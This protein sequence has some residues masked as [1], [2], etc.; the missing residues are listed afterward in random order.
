MHRKLMKHQEWAAEQLESKPGLFLPCGAGKTLVAIRY[1][2]RHHLFPALIVCRKDDVLTWTTELKEEGHYEGSQVG[3]VNKE[4]PPGY[5][6]WTIVTYD[7]LKNM[8]LSSFRVAVADESWMVKRW[9]AKRTKVL[10]KRT[11][12]IP[13]RIAMSATP[14]TQD[15]G[16]VFTQSLFMDGGKT[17]GA[18]YWAFLNKY[19]VQLPHGGWVLKRGWAKLEILRKFE[20]L[21]ITIDDPIKIP[22][23]RLMKS[24]PISGKQRRLQEKLLSD[25]EYQLADGDVV[26]LKYIISQLGKLKQLASGFMYDEDGVAHWMKS[27]KLDL[28][29]ELVTNSDLL[30]KKPKL[31]IWCAYVA[32][33]EKIHRVFSELGIQGVTFYGKKNKEDSRKYFKTCP[34]IRLFIGQADSGVG[35]NELGIAD[36]A[37]YFSNSYRVLSRK[38]S[39]GRLRGKRSI[40]KHVTYYDLVTEGTMDLEVLHQLRQGV[41]LSDYVLER[42]RQGQKLSSILKLGAD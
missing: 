21:S 19:Y 38:Q 16:D 39:E 33:I 3:V 31:V 1:I 27:Y 15:I 4:C 10:I 5:W 18:S 11:R 9:K 41:S 8:T 2:I 42:L 40:H 24:A 14:T 25:W 26:E 22:T 37:I 7:R 12:N 23:R 35:I 29:K 17:F 36:T 28:L 13:V 20:K 6:K 30:G 32:E 34:D